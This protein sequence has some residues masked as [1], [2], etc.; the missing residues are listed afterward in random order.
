MKKSCEQ[1]SQYEEILKKAEARAVEYPGN[2]HGMMAEGKQGTGKGRALKMGMEDFLSG[3]RDFLDEAMAFL[4]F[5]KT[6]R[7]F[8]GR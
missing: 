6:Y 3:W 2:T 1:V 8:V 4:D 7:F 5:L